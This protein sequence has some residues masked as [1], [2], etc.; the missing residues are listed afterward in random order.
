MV[1]SHMESSKKLM[2]PDSKHYQEQYDPNQDFAIFGMS[3]KT[4]GGM[5][6]LQ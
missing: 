3:D 6:T 1:T 4:K 2:K 5:Q